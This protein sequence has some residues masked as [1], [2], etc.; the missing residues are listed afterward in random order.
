MPLSIGEPRSSD[1]ALVCPVCAPNRRHRAL[2]QGD[3]AG[4]ELLLLCGRVDIVF[5]HEFQ[6]SI[7]ADTKHADGGRDYVLMPV[8]SRT[9]IGQTDAV[10]R[11]RPV[12]SIPKV[13][14]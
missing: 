4:P 9:G 2:R 3:H 10:T 6:F 12:G 11:I 7:A 14:R 1:P 5:A 8:P 13:R